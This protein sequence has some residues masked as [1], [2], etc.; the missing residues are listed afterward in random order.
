M[1]GQQQSGK[2]RKV[3]V[4][5]AK[6]V[7]GGELPDEGGQGLGEITFR[8]DERIEREQTKLRLPG[9]AD[10]SFEHLHGGRVLGSAQQRFRRSYAN[11]D[12][13]VF[14]Q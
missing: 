7:R 10:G 12:I 13:A 9:L 4:E 8:P 14:E 2:T 11:D 5:A 1:I 6:L 3:V